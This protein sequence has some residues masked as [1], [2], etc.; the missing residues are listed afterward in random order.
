VGS[1]LEKV[2]SKLKVI[3]LHGFLG[4][5]A[6]WDLV[7]SYFMISPLAHQFEWWAV[8]YMNTPGLDPSNDFANW[9][10]NFNLKVRQ[11]FV[12]GPCVL[13]G[14]SLGGRLAL[15]ALQAAPEL[16]AKAVFV[17][18][19]PGLQRDQDKEDRAQND[20]QWSQ[21]FLEMPWP[22]LMKE[23]GAQ[24]VFKDSLAE[25][26]R[27]EASYSRPLL[28]QSLL[29]WSLAQQAD[30]RNLIAQQSEKIL[31]VAGEKDI[32]FASISMGLKRRSPALESQIFAKSSHRVLFDQPHELAQAMIQF[33]D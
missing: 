25:P 18:T 3:C 27:L 33:F 20:L 8:D 15:H 30:F 22:A 12:E 2:G 31:W 11:K 7:K 16:Y 4:K 19:N 32:K 1:A 26:Q 23:W 9:A 10:C 17:S 29:Q 6:D 13:V 28:A 21:K 24:G 14:Y 5:P